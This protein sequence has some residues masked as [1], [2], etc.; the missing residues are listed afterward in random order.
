MYWAHAVVGISLGWLGFILV[1]YPLWL[2]AR[3]HW[4]RRPIKRDVSMRPRVSLI[5]AAHNEAAGML[6]KLQNTAALDYP[7]DRWEAII[8]DDGSTDHTAG[9]VLAFG[10]PH[11][12]LIRLPRGGKTHALNAA[13]R[14]ATGD[15]LVFTDADSLL[16]PDALQALTAPFSDTSVGGVAG[17]FYY[18]GECGD[19]I[20]ER[21]HWTGDRRFKQWQSESGSVTSATGQLYAIRTRL[22]REIPSGVSD[23]FYVSAGVVQAGYRLVFAPEARAFGPGNASSSA[24]FRR[25]L[26]VFAI[27]Y[28]GAWTLRRLANP[29]RYGFYAVQFVTQKALYRLMGVPAL[30]LWAASAG[31]ASAHPVFRL[32]FLGQCAFHMLA[33]FGWMGRRYE[34]ARFKGFAFP[35]A[36]DL[37]AWAGLCGLFRALTVGDGDAWTPQRKDAGAESAN[38]STPGIAYCFSR[39]PLV[40][41]TFVLNEILWLQEHGMRVEVFPL[42]R[43]KARVIHRGAESI[44]RCMHYTPLWSPRLWRDQAYWLFR[45]PRAYID[46]W[47]KA[48]WGNRRSRKF[49][50]RALVAI[51][52]AARYARVMQALKI[53][54]VHV[55][56]ATH[57]ALTAY[58]IRKLTGIP[59]TLTVHSGD[60]F[61]DRSML[62]EKM[63]ASEGVV[64]ISDFNKRYLTELYGNDIGRKIQV[65]R[66]GVRLEA[67]GER[68]SRSF[69][70]PLVVC[71]ASFDYYK[72]HRVL[73]SACN[74]L[75]K[76]GVAF[77]CLC[78]GQGPD[79]GYIQGLVREHGLERHI[80]LLGA[81]PH[82]VVLRLLGQASL[83]VLPSIVM[84][85]GKTEGIPV[86][87]MESL[88]LG[89]PVVASRLSGIPELVDSGEC[90]G[91]L[92]PQKDPE[93]LADAMER[94]L[95]DRPW[96]DRLAE[97]GRDRVRQV[98]DLNRNMDMK[99]QFI[100]ERVRQAPA[101]QNLNEALIHSPS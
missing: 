60:I 12:R 48:L 55:H 59:Y 75:R 38:T 79:F 19:N 91:L 20:G 43:E 76:R 6:E 73:V 24:E 15:V 49:F 61:A 77:R 8:A 13:V 16:K 82:H 62:K 3:A 25:K 41:E 81:R 57:A 30:A 46:C 58:G 99:K 100:E 80:R 10:H 95:A 87:L 32:L 31:A 17:N 90:G 9:Q 50:L 51:P 78:V 53:G 88:G 39:F 71:V 84:D 64:A 74:R 66:C 21:A 37:T 68:R 92:V 34:W 11:I 27:G 83:S 65:I 93:A 54:H 69:P 7:A 28:R 52:L 56:F 44:V 2:A 85:T 29:F 96:A 45:R 26:R 98:Y 67:L 23:D 14:E 89:V 40:T 63:E 22:F 101:P 18:R 72:G 42:I 33:L 86:A 4:I 97:R 94:L 47:V 35:Y 5:I 70:I 1:L 36:F